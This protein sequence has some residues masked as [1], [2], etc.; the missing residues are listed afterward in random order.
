MVTQVT[1]GSFFTLANG[2]TVLGGTGGSG[3]DTQSLVK[4]LTEA[5]QVPVKKNEDLIALNDKQS[6]ALSTLQSLLSNFRSSADAL[7]NPPGVGNAADNVFKFTIGSV[8]T[9]ASPY[10]GITTSAGATLQDYEIK[11]ISSIATSARQGTGTFAVA[12]A[13]A[14]VVPSGGGV[15]F[16]A[17]TITFNGEDITIAAG[18]SLNVIAAKFNAVSAET[19]VTATVIAVSSTSYKLSFV[20]KNTGTDGN[21]DLS[22]AT[23]PS[24]VLTNIGLTAATA[25]TNAAFKLNGIDIV[26]QS[27]VVNDVVSGVTFNI[28]QVT[29]DAVTPYTVSVKPD[30][31]TIQNAINNFIANYNAIKEFEAEQTQLNSDGTYAADS[32]LV[33]NQTFLGIMNNV[34]SEINGQVAGLLGNNPKSLVDIGITFTNQPATDDSP[35]VDNILTVNDGQLTSAL[36]SNFEG[37]SRLFG[38]NLTSDNS[39]LTIFSHTNSL[40]VT[41]VTLNINPGTNTFTAT[42]N[43]GDGNVTVDLTAT[44]LSGGVDGYALKGPAGSALEGLQLIYASTATAT[45]TAKFTQGIADR[46]FNSSDFALKVNTGSIAIELTGIKERTDRLNVDIANLNLQ[47]EVFQQQLIS[48]FSALEQAI[49]R[50][51][52]LLSSM[53]ANDQQR[54]IAAQ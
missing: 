41:D 24:G 9:A 16:A 1:L 26:R 5:K 10:V 34:N 40:S 14:D 32:V 44:P 20:A 8:S 25:G 13:D 47:I 2:K 29:P 33:N 28:L 19:G 53:A 31:V 27:N 38:F 3:L 36:S 50:V 54:F 51:N 23:D 52:N 12:S 22:T 39:N 48:K 49:S 17:G 18:D 4:S 15:T 37:V 46:I 7:R 30:T 21:F 43:P 42:Y 35:E 11:D 6:S 45:I